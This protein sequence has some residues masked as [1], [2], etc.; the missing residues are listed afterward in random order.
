M[1]PGDVRESVAETAEEIAAMEVRGAAT[2]ARE[3]VEALRDQA[4][5]S[6]AGDA[7]TLRMELQTAARRLRETRPTAVSLP[8][9]LRFVLERM[10]GDDLES[11]R[12]SVVTT[13]DE[14]LERLDRAQADLGR[15]GANRLQDGDTVMT[16]CHSTDVLA[17]IETAREQGKE[18]DAVVKE[19]RPRKQ[20]H[21]TAKQLRDL[22]VPVTLIVDSAATRYIEDVDHVFVGAD[23]IRADGSVVNKIGTRGLAVLARDVGTPVTVAAQTLKL[24]P[25]TF[26]G[27]A[28][29]IENRADEE[30]IDEETRSDLG[31][32]EVANPAF[33][34]TPP[35]HVDAVVTERGLFPPE[36]IVALM[37]ELYGTTPTRPWEEGET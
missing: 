2:I 9:A 36:G 5:E 22:G 33:D 11:L 15:I 19:T 20:G 16:H 23:S 35:R 17:C 4:T 13:A 29:E 10:E 14:F 24:D 3:A 1:E 12:A 28:V 26:A 34:V 30:V 7:E 25:D 27:H 8:N 32:V 21:L 6:T 31:E 18:L 37:R